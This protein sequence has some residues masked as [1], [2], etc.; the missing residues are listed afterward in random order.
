MKTP[1]FCRRKALANVT[2]SAYSVIRCA[3]S[4]VFFGIIGPLTGP[5]GRTAEITNARNLYSWKG[6]ASLMQLGLEGVKDP[7]GCQFTVTVPKIT[8]TDVIQ[9]VPCTAEA[10]AS[11]MGVYTWKCIEKGRC[12]GD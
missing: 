7:G 12:T 8:V 10:E 4:G 3:N 2:G 11:I 6:A 1:W 5:L 9:V